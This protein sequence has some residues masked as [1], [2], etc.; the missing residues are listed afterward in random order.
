MN[1]ESDKVKNY[2]KLIERY[3]NISKPN[4]V[5][6]IK[7]VIWPVG[8]E[9]EYYM[10]I[11]YVVPDDSKYLKVNDKNLIPVRYRDEWNH[12]ITKDLKDYFGLKVYINQS[13]T[14]NENFYN[15]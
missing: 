10:K 5:L 14:R 11:M 2:T 1:D 7:F 13:G 12:Q 15:R 3:L 4:G 9:N 6:E 8:D